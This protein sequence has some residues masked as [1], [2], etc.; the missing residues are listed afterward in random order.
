MTQSD[1]RTPHPLEYAPP[2]ARRSRALTVPFRGETI[3]AV[4]HRTHILSE[5]ELGELLSPAKLKLPDR[6]R[7]L[8]IKG[9]AYEDWNGEESLQVYVILDDATPEE[10]WTLERIEPIY[11][12]IR[13]RLREAEEPRFPYITAGTRS[14][15]DRRYTYDPSLD[16]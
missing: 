14:D 7:V 10:D 11:D 8:D 4:T 1:P 16:E 6:P 15:Y 5:A 13:C 12:A 2:Q 9:H 3:F